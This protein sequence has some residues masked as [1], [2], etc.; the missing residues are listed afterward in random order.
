MVYDESL[1]FHSEEELLPEKETIKGAVFK[2][3]DNYGQQQQQ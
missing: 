3:T 2:K 1:H